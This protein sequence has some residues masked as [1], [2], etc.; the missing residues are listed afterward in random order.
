MDQQWQDESISEESASR[1]DPYLNPD[2]HEVWPGDKVSY[3][4]DEKKTD[5][6]GSDFIFTKK[7]GVVQNVSQER[8]ARVQWYNDPSIMLDASS[9]A[10]ES[11]FSSY[12]PIGNDITDVSLYE[13]AAHPGLEIS[14][15]DMV[16]ALPKLPRLSA[17]DSIIYEK[18]RGLFTAID[19]STNEESEPMLGLGDDRIRLLDDAI[20]R[21][22]CLR[23]V[24]V[25]QDR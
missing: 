8:I 13:I 21:V 2:E 14:R 7:V 11:P 22:I 16:L 9:K 19:P 4:P 24:R 6:H 25:I 17:S 23:T 15:G 20:A 3:I 18:R 5:E 12:G 10:L 1:L